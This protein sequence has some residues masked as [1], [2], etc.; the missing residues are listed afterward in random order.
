MCLDHQF[1]RTARTQIPF[2]IFLLQKTDTVHETEYPDDP[3]YGTVEASCNS[4]A[5]LLGGNV[6]PPDERDAITGETVE[7][8]SQSRADNVVEGLAR[9][10]V[11]RNDLSGETTEV[12]SSHSR[13]D[14][15]IGD[16][17]PRLVAGDDLLGEAGGT[18][19]LSSAD[20]VF[21]N[22]FPQRSGTNGGNLA[23]VN[24][25]I[26]PRMLRES[27]FV[28]LE[29]TPITAS[30]SQPS[31]VLVT[32]PVVPPFKSLLLDDHPVLWSSD[33]RDTGMKTAPR[34]DRGAL[35]DRTVARPSDHR[36]WRRLEARSE[37]CEGQ[38]E[39]CT[40]DVEQ[41]HSAVSC[42]AAPSLSIAPSVFPATPS[43]EA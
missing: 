41:V 31:D 17:A 3:S 20:S 13:V 6:V 29:T 16:D 11:G 8:I 43:A 19:A 33:D 28:E 39:V 24:V 26:Q 32:A 18:L 25:A 21:R 14:S 35:A 30:V 34:V 4:C 23:S 7:T 1:S 10:P 36:R 42:E 40:P 37:T 5:D 15:V 38:V 2:L 27:V 22:D 12:T 9:R